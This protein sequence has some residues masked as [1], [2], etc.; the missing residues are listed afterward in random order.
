MPPA[1]GTQPGGV[2]ITRLKIEKFRAVGSAEIELGDTVALVGQNGSGKSSILRALNAFFNF[3]DEKA[4]FAQAFHARLVSVVG[5]VGGVEPGDDGEQLGVLRLEGRGQGGRAAMPGR[6]DDLPLVHEVGVA[7]QGRRAP[8]VAFDADPG[9]RQRLGS[10]AHLDA[11]RQARLAAVDARHTE[12]GQPR[13]PG[14]VGQDHGLG[15][16]Q[17]QGRP[18]PPHRDLHRLLARGL[19]AAIAHE[20][21]VVIRPIEVLRLAAHDLAL[22][23]ELR[24][25]PMQEGQLQAQ[26]RDR[27][28]HIHVRLDALQP[29]LGNHRVQA[30]VPQVD[31]DGHPLEPR[32]R[33]LQSQRG[34][35]ES[36]V[37]RDGGAFAAFLQGVGLHHVVGEHGDLVTRH[38]DGGQALAGDS[39]EGRRRLQREAGR[40][41]VDAD[42]DGTGAQPLHRE[43]VVDLRGRRIVDRE[44]LRLAQRQ[45]LANLRR[46]KRREARALGKVVEQKALPVELVR[47]GDGAGLLQQVQRRRVG[48]ARGL[49]HRLVLGSVLVGLEQDLEQLVADRR[50]A[51]PRGQF[52]GPGLDLRLHLFFL[53]DRGQGLLQDLGRRLL[54]AALAGAAE[55][56]RRLEQAQQR[57][58][59]LLQRRLVGEIVARQVGEA[60]LLLRREFPGQFELDGVRQR[61]GLVHQLGGR[62]FLEFQQ[63]VGGL[64]LDALAAVEFHLRR[65]LGFGQH[66]ARLELPGF[67]KQYE[68]RRD[69]PM[70]MFQLGV[71]APMKSNTSSICASKSDSAWSP[72]SSSLMCAPA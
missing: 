15:D 27:V 32:L 45:L 60:E 42:G 1:P 55:V 49:D 64:D 3:E 20:T 26:V 11:G 62:G 54:E 52:R 61:L 9:M 58:G 63:D 68:H 10:H 37:Q 14:A 43:R 39:V 17:V 29:L 50:R 22:R 8:G 16:D 28:G 6:R 31:G 69:C 53:F 7:A 13:A 35:V 21:E 51:A 48:I 46:R 24:G 19:G 23:L 40:R 72:S 30:V 12:F 57:R 4:D 59:L 34:L 66:A 47:A 44:G 36:R 33:F 71:P 18:A 70:Q 38:V 65:G 56:V 25:Q 41:D 67:F 2:R 5:G